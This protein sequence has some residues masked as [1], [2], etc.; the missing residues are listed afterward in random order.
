MEFSP[1]G[2]FQGLITFILNKDKFDSYNIKI[3]ELYIE[4]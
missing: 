4:I 3:F 1:I 2:K